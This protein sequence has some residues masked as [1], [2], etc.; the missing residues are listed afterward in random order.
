MTT[1]AGRSGWIV[2]LYLDD[3]GR[4]PVA[5]FLQGM[6]V[7][8]RAKIARYLQLLQEFGPLLTMPHA[9]RLGGKLWELRPDAFRVLYFAHTGQ[10]F[11]ILHVYRKKSRRAPRK[12][13]ELALRRLDNVLAREQKGRT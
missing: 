12:E 3:N 6:P 9:R 4:S 5:E 2:E 13:I 11:I 7:Q 8:D 1:Q 10:R